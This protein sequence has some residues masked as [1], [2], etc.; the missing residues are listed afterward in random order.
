MKKIELRIENTEY[1]DIDDLK[2]LQGD[3]EEAIRR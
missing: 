2:P 1:I 3:L